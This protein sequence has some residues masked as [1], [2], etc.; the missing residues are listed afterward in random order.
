[1]PNEPERRINFLATALEQ[2]NATIRGKTDELSLMR[3]VAD[4]ISQHTSLWSLSGELVNAIAQG[5]N[6]KYAIIYCGSTE[7]NPFQLQAVS[8]IFSGSEQFPANIH[9]TRLVRHLEQNGSPLQIDNVGKN[10]IWSEDWPF[11]NGLLSWLCVPLLTRNHVRGA[12]ILA[13]DAAAA[14][15][16]RTLRTLMIVVPQMT[17]AFANI[18]LY[19]HLR[20]SELKYRTLVERIQDVVYICDRKWQILDANPAAEALFGVNITG[21]TL[22]DLFAS[23]KNASQFM[24]EVRASL[25]V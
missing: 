7:S 18:G 16:E 6:C 17:S 25:M 24:E 9:D 14:F 23:P 5:V 21:R 4:S 10:A 20:Q 12:L 19:N 8:N 2:A 15:D 22:M 3:R 11:P 1:M 13:D